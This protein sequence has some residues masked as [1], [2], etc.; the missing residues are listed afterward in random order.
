VVLEKGLNKLRRKPRR[1]GDGFFGDWDS[2]SQMSLD[3]CRESLYEVDLFVPTAVAS[4]SSRP[5]L[6]REPREP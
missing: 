3:L 1:V 2:T 6:P 4:E 5:D